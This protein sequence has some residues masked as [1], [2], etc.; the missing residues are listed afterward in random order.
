M[1]Q[2]FYSL[3]QIDGVIMVSVWLIVELIAQSFN[4]WLTTKIVTKIVDT[5]KN[6]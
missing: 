2:G 1:V 4:D 3:D 5:K 6:K